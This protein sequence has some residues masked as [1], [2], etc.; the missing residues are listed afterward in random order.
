MTL[1]L[2]PFFL[3]VTISACGFQPIYSQKNQANV[4]EN[5]SQIRISNIADRQGQILRNKLIDKLYGSSARPVS[6]KYRLSIQNLDEIISSVGI[7]KDATT[8]R[9]RITMTATLILEDYRG[10]ILLERDL[11]SVNSYNIL[12]SQYG[13]LITRQDAQQRTLDELSDEIQTILSLY[14]VS[15]NTR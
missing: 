11:K 15:G 7:K 4:S 14:F 10:D 6:P 12:D 1:L 2:L 8:T 13:T 9:G 3:V 5:M